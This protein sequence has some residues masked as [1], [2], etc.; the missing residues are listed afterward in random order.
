MAPTAPISQKAHIQVV[1]KT[2]DAML[3][4]GETE[5]LRGQKRIIN[6]CK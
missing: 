4:G 1:L 2:N 5:K 3:P 6:P